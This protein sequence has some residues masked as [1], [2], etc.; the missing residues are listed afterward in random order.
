[1][2][3]T[4]AVSG[5]SNSSR[6]GPASKVIWR[7]CSCRGTYI[8][9]GQTLFI[10]DPT[11]YR[12]RANKAKAQ[13]NKARAQALK[14]ERDLNRIRPLYEQN[15]ASQLDLDNAIASYESA[16]ADVVVSEADLTQAE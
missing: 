3:S 16:V 11:V 14:A 4:W 6:S 1:M 10:I 2:A 12:A 13:L 9:K 5:P 8:K 15:A 7:R